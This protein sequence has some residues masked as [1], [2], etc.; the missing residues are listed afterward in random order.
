[1]ATKDTLLKKQLT[2]EG[3]ISLFLLAVLG[4]AAFLISTY[5]DDALS[6]KQAKQNENNG[7]Q[8]ETSSIQQQLG[9]GFE[10]SAYYEAYIRNH[11]ADLLPKREAAAQLMSSLRERDHLTNMSVTISPLSDSPLEFAPLKSG[12]AVK[13]D[14]QVTFGSITDNSTYEFI[15]G[16][17]RQLPGLALIKD[18]KI[19]HTS[20]L[21]REVILALSQH[22][23]TPLIASDISF[24]WLGIK[25][26]E[27]PKTPPANGQ[28]NGAR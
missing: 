24:V 12:T 4:G 20:D 23:I 8:S 16:L 22:K 27:E 9:S 17:Q 7:M 21:S 19:T 3:I 2:R 1:M 26:A 28:E 6:E 13:S 18:L 25:P 11:N 5:D 10:V 14:V 15:A